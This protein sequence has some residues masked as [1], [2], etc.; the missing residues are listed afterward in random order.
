MWTWLATASAV[1][2]VGPWL[3]LWWDD[4]L[5]EGSDQPS[6]RLF[7]FYLGAAIAPLLVA[8]TA[9]LAGWW[10]TRSWYVV[11]RRAAVAALIAGIFGWIALV[12]AGAVVLSQFG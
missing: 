5:G 9:A 4:E 2:V 10:R 11:W 8:A 12:V 3:Y 1:A 6:L 7:L